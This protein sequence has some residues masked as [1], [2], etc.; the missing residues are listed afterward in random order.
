MELI[1]LGLVLIFAGIGGFILAN[2][3]PRSELWW[4][5][6]PGNWNRARPIPP[7]VIAVGIALVIIGA[8]T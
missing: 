7:V 6:R 8:L 5:D 1:G 4:P 3:G 2:V